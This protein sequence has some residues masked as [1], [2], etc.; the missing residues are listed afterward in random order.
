MFCPC[1]FYRC[2]HSVPCC[3][4]AWHLIPAENVCIGRKKSGFNRYW[5][6]WINN[7]I[8]A[9]ISLSRTNG[10]RH[11]LKGNFKTGKQRTAKRTQHFFKEL[12]RSPPEGLLTFHWRTDGRTR[13]DIQINGIDKTAVEF[14]WSNRSNSPRLSMACSLIWNGNFTPEGARVGLKREAG[15]NGKFSG[16]NLSLLVGH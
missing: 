8:P 16:S 5:I 6:F 14:L 10:P 9:Q 15:Q 1:T 3:P 13:T 12:A 2:L 4:C 11:N 7:D